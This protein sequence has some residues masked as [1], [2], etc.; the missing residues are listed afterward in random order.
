[1]ADV[2]RIC[3]QLAYIVC[4]YRLEEEDAAII[5]DAIEALRDKYPEATW[6][7]IQDPV[8]GRSAW[9]CTRCGKIAR[10]NPHDKIHCSICGARMRMEA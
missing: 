5:S 7:Y 9:R 4:A 6:E 2:G 10:R 1:M 3:G 8:T